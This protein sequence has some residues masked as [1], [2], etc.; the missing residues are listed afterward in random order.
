VVKIIE[1]FLESADMDIDNSPIEWRRE[2]LQ[3]ALG[4]NEISSQTADINKITRSDKTMDNKN[5]P[6]NLFNQDLIENLTE[7]ERQGKELE[8]QFKRIDDKAEEIVKLLTGFTASDAE[9]AIQSA[10]MKLKKYSVVRFEE[11]SEK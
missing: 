6:F 10:V 4:N 3:L 7:L 9:Q 2:K 8:A 5:F 1:E 11:A